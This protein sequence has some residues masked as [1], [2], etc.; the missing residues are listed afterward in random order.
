MKTILRTLLSLIVCMAC[1]NYGMA[2]EAQAGVTPVTHEVDDRV[3]ER[4]D[5]AVIE[6]VYA[7]V[8]KSKSTI[9]GERQVVLADFFKEQDNLIA[10][11]VQAKKPKFYIDSVKRDQQKK[12][13]E[14]LTPSEKFDYYT[15]PKTG[16]KS[17]IS[18]SQ[19]SLAVKNKE[20]LG[21]SE[22]VVAK[23]LQGIDTL[24]AKKDAFYRENSGKSFDSRPLESEMMIS[25][26]SEGQ[27][28]KLLYIKNKF[29]ARTYAQNDW[30]EMETRGMAAVLNKDSTIAALT[31]FY[32][33]R[34]SAYDR[35]NHD[36]IQQSENVRLVYENR[37][38]AL[39]MLIHARRNPQNNTL[40]QSY[41][42]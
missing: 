24:K 20:I 40:G 32:I 1:V 33:A 35:Y 15:A 22:E 23:L 3:S 17:P 28:T 19:L 12:F 5:A 9:S 7:F 10:S 13:I 42:W 26:L 16:E 25:L 29:K 21:L 38:Q 18:Y 41:N 31:N 34:Q 37:P 30:K 11:L 6:K 39:N 14:L 27:Y 36:K 8:S 2:Q 4:Y